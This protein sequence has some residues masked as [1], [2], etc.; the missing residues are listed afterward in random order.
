MEELTP[1]EEPKIIDIQP[2]KKWRRTLLFLGDFF[3]V[4]IASLL[5]FHLAIYPLGRTLVNYDGQITSLHNAQERRDSILYHYELLFPAT[6][7]AVGYINFEDNLAFT[8]K[9]YIHAMTD[10]TYE[11]KYDVFRHYFRQIRND[12]SAWI[13]FYTQL[14]EKQGFFDITPSSVALK[15]KY[16]QEFAPAFNP[17][18]TMSAQGKE[19]YQKF[20]NK[21]F[22][23]GYDLLLKDLEKNDLTYDG[24][25]YKTEQ[26]IVSTVLLN[27]R[28]L[29]VVCALV[30]LL[31]TWMIN[32]LLI[33]TFSKKRKTLA[34]MFLR[35][36]RVHK[37]TLETVSLPMAYLNSFYALAAEAV[38]VMFIPWGTTNFNELFSLPILFP[39]ALFSL[40]FLLG[41]TVVMLLDAYN[42]TLGDLLCQTHCLSADEF[43]RLVMERGYKQ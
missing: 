23:Q 38:M 17:D 35:V 30:T 33:P 22:A 27:G 10:P 36:E 14:D 41:S 28:R 4:F 18:D 34:M 7:Y 9:N 29:V 8:A 42:R 12:D 37:K 16:K 32:H 40:A 25:S 19:D 31:L 24:K 15:E 20:E 21:I 5:L 39:V 1:V 26:G 3:L 13:S 11:A 6:E 43:D 2:L